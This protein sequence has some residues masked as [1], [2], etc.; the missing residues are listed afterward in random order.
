MSQKAVKKACSGP[1]SKVER[2]KISCWLQGAKT[3][4]PKVDGPLIYHHVLYCEPC[5][6]D[7]GPYKDLPL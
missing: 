4:G 7:L 6:L 3:D 1:S 5:S 2:R